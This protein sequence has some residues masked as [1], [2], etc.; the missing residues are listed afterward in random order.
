[1]RFGVR[2]L[3]RVL[4][5]AAVIVGVVSFGAQGITGTG[6]SA[7]G[8]TAALGTCQA[9]MS[10]ASQYGTITSIIRAE[11]STASSVAA[12]QENRAR[13]GMPSQLRQITG[14]TRLTVCMFS[15]EFSTPSGPPAADGTLR[16]APDTLRLLVYGSGTVVF[17][18]AG[19]RAA[20]T[21]EMPSDMVGVHN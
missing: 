12:W 9:I 14:S 3:S 2:L 21:P 10:V 4:V 13:R 8:D 11:T 1:M 20:M 5:I 15:G 7:R 17:D 18:S 16:A 19:P 6:S